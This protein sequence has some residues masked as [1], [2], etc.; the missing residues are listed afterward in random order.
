A[1]ASKP[2]S[3]S[4][5]PPSREAE[6]PMTDDTRSDG[7]AGGSRAG[8]M[9][10]SGPVAERHRFDQDALVAWLERELP[11]FRGP[12]TVEQFRGGQSNPTFRLVTPARSY[13]M[14]A[15]PGPAAKLL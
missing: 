14:R 5:R 13:V 11:D 9:T 15:K 4:A 3:P 2:S 8:A 6:S 12:L 10:G 1:K 7:D